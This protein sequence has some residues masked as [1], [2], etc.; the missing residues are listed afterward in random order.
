MFVACHVC[1]GRLEWRKQQPPRPNL[2]KRCHAGQLPE[3]AA[4]QPA[5]QALPCW[6][7]RTAVYRGQLK[8]QMVQQ[9]AREACRAQLENTASR[10]WDD[11]G[12]Q[13]NGPEKGVP[14]LLTKH[15]CLPMRLT[16]GG[17]GL[18]T[19]SWIYRTIPKHGA[20]TRLAPI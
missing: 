6:D 7:A 1:C 20:V 16:G 18:P 14:A 11:Q 3:R 2:L 5:A 13:L 4:F 19:C 10:L 17:I 8:I 15:T 9:L 12:T